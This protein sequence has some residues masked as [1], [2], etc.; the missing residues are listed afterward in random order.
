MALFPV[1][2]V[3]PPALLDSHTRA[4]LARSKEADTRG[5]IRKRQPAGTWEYILDVGVYAAQRCQSCGRRTWVERKPKESCP[6]CGG[7]LRETEERRRET[8]AGF[9]SRRECQAALTAKLTT[10]A[11]HTYVPP[12]HFSVREF[13][14]EGLAAGD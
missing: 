5:H 10:L 9:A 4:K 1:L 8:K 13:L 7:R 14:D 11:Q 6:S 2:S 12:S 3:R